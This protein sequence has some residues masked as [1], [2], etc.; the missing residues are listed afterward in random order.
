MPGQVRELDNASFAKGIASG[1]VLVEFYGTW[2]PPCK[3]LEPVL[4][5][6]AAK[7]AGQAAVGKIN[8]DDNSETAVEQSIADIPTLVFFQNGEEIR[9]LYGAKSLETLSETLDRLLADTRP[10]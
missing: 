8:I 1:V 7:Y 10:G 5:E 9:R 2:C 4:E 6:L 3:L